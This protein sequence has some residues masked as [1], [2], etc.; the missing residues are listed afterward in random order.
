MLD[1]FLVC[2]SPFVLITI[3]LQQ[4]RRTRIAGGDRGVLLPGKDGADFFTV[5]INVVREALWMVD[6]VAIEVPN[7]IRGHRM[8]PFCSIC[9]D[10][11][12]ILASARSFSCRI[13]SLQ[14]PMT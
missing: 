12:L 3:A 2:V 11:A 6:G 7:R 8:T 4:R 10:A 14:Q 5:R 1:S 13:R 9:S